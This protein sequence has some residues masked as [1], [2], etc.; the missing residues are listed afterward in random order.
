MPFTSCRMIFGATGP[1]LPTFTARSTGDPT[2][3]TPTRN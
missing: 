1:D 2:I 3:S